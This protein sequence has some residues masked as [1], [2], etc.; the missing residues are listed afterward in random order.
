MDK[1]FPNRAQKPGAEKNYVLVVPTRSQSITPCHVTLP[2]VSS[3]ELSHL[4]VRAND[5]RLRDIVAFGFKQTSSDSK[6]E[7][8][9]PAPRCMV[10]TGTTI[11]CAAGRVGTV[12]QHVFDL[13]V[14]TAEEKEILHVCDVLIITHTR[15]L[16]HC[17]HTHTHAFCLKAC[18]TH[19]KS[20]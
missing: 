20:L 19:T 4:R 16:T 17:T 18:S 14:P 7:V 6:R 1:A 5:T 11:L 15:N 3:E 8:T 10:Q 12:F 2:K 9:V 13:F